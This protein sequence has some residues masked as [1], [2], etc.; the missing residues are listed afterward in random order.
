MAAGAAGAALVMRIFYTSINGQTAANGGPQLRQ[1]HTHTHTDTQAYSDTLTQ[2]LALAIRET[3]VS[4]CLWGHLTALLWRASFD[5]DAKM[6]THGLTT[7]GTIWNGTRFA[8]FFPSLTLSIS[9][10]PGF[11]G[12]LSC[13]SH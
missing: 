9:L 8:S 5:K 12:Q 6:A 13:D 10:Y 1:L 3:P 11:S 2:T 4:H 7:Y